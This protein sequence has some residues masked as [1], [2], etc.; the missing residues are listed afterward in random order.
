MEAFI[1]PKA[2][3]AQNCLCKR[4]W[5][6]GVVVGYF[7]IA[8]SMVRLAIT[9]ISPK[10][11]KKSLTDMRPEEMSWGTVLVTIFLIYSIIFPACP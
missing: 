11:F 7:Y 8:T 1:V 4:G 9:E 3:M 2:I 6:M 5:E 10:S